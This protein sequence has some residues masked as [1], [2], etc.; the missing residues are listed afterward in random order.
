[1]QEKE[2][3]V[4]ARCNASFA[5]DLCRKLWNDRDNLVISPFSIAT[6]AA[7]MYA[8]SRGNTRQQIAK[9]MHLEFEEKELHAAFGVLN[10]FINK[11]W[12]RQNYL[13]AANAIWICGGRTLSEGFRTLA[14]THYESHVVEEKEG[15]SADATKREINDWIANKTKGM[16]VDLLEELDQQTLFM[17]IS[18][19]CFQDDWR[20]AFKK[21]ETREELFHL[22][23][24][25]KIEVPMMRQAGKFRYAESG[26]LKVLDLPY[27][28]NNT[29]LQIFLPKAIDG[30]IDR[31]RKNAI[32]GQRKRQLR[33]L[34]ASPQF[35]LGSCQL[36]ELFL[37]VFL[38]LSQIVRS[39]VGQLAFQ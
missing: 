19:I 31:S 27:M 4:L 1:M 10:M 24:D 16:I 18:A 6:V 17:L 20:S 30:I 15:Q 5:I 11:P 25:S 32:S 35:R 39:P 28:S 7:L 22:G 34:D 29:S 23:S 9:V 38:E 26:D 14:T 8:G 37:Q 12:A 13:C 33:L 21:A 2:Y 36:P 3:K